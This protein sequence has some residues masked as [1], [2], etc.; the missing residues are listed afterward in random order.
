MR[1]GLKF[2]ISITTTPFAKITNKKAPVAQKDDTGT[3]INRV[4]TL[5]YSFFTKR[6]S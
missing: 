4:T 5:F 6:A 2:Q 1:E 3:A